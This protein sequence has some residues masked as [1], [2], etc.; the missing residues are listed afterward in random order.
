M[1]FTS[2]EKAA[3]VA[4][5]KDEFLNGSKAC[6]AEYQTKFN[7]LSIEEQFSIIKRAN[8]YKAKKVETPVKES[9]TS[10]ISK[11]MNGTIVEISTEEAQELSEKFKTARETLKKII[12]ENRI[13]EKQNIEQQIEELQAKLKELK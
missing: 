12:A 10:I 5:N 6:K 8:A 4:A 11:L 13:R 2:E 1:K 7:G 3:Y 9:N